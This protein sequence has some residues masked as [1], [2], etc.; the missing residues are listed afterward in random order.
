MK[1]K[2]VVRHRTGTVSVEGGEV[3][4]RLAG[5]GGLRQGGR[6]WE[7]DIRIP[8]SQAGATVEGTQLTIR[9]EGRSVQA[10]FGC[11]Y[12]ETEAFLSVL[13]EA[14]QAATVVRTDC[15][16]CGAPAQVAG[17]PCTYCK[18]TVR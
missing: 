5:K 13:D 15:N 7:Q 16:H 17:K 10:V 8:V 12:E 9:R 18:A 1:V 11:S 14:Y 2:G 4:I 3:V 6:P